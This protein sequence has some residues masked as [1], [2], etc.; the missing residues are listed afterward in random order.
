MTTPVPAK[1]GGSTLLAAFPAAVR[2]RLEIQD[3]DHARKEILLRS[4]EQADSIL[5]P[6]R[7]TVISLTRS[8]KTGATVEI[9]LVGA[10][11]AASP[12]ALLSGGS[13]GAEAVIQISGSLSRVPLAL[14]REALAE[15]AEVRSLLLLFGA[16][17]LGQ[18]SQHVLCN[19]V[20][21]IEQR[22]AKWLLSVRDRI[23]TDRLELT[24]EF[25]SHMLG[26]R[27]SGVTVAIGLLELDGLI[28][29]SRSAVSV[30]DR[31]GL[32]NR[33]CECYRVIARDARPLLERLAAANR[34]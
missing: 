23:D 24:H 4:D 15:N 16:T 5:F 9:G 6:H 7:G 2:E 8:T 22:L 28:S 21:T 11:G 31:S 18:V 26:I 25:L 17:Y 20:H 14:I 29:H 19:R 1:A 30:T 12:Q 10:E 27:R 32:E 33:A 34:N 13:N 3:E